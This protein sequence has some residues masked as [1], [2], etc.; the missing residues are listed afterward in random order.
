MSIE[1][2]SVSGCLYD[3][4]EYPGAILGGSGAVFGEVVA[5]RHLE[6][7]LSALDLEEGDE[8]KRVPIDALQAWIY[9]LKSVPSGR[10]RIESGDWRR[11]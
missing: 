10:R 6:A 9:V 4:G 3:L 7:I 1:P 8:Y 2:S 11:R 5:F